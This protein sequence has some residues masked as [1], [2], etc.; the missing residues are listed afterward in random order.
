MVLVE[1]GSGFT[2]CVRL[3]V[4]VL[5]TE[6]SSVVTEL[7]DFLYF[8]FTFLLKIHVPLPAR[9]KLFTNLNSIDA[10]PAP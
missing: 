10:H 8:F 3:E 1:F 6:M 5:E 2:V 4:A 7:N 9:T